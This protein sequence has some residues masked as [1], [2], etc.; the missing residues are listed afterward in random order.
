[1]IEELEDIFDVDESSSGSEDSVSDSASCDSLNLDNL[2]VGNDKSDAAKKAVR[3]A[4]RQ[5]SAKIDRK[6]LSGV[7][8]TEPVS[9]GLKK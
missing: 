4:S 9:A 2:E 5:V 1:M 6:V 7:V 3:K 8:T